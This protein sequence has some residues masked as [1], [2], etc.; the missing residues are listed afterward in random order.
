VWVTRLGG[1]MLV[2]VGVLLVT[3]LWTEWIGQLRALFPVTEVP[4]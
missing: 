4:L 2:V 1:A 3:G